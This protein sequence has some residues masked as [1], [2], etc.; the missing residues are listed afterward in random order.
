MLHSLLQFFSFP[1]YACSNTYNYKVFLFYLLGCGKLHVWLADGQ[2][3]LLFA[4]CM[5]KRKVKISCTIYLQIKIFTCH[6][7]QVV[8]RLG[9]SLLL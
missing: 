5:M 1:I 2:W 3:E 4:H 9:Q 7:T 6:T 8:E